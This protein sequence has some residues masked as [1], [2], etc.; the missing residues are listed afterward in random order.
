MTPRSVRPAP[1]QLA[2]A[3]AAPRRVDRAGLS[4]VLGTVAGDDTLLVV[5]ADGTAGS[6]L[7]RE[8]A[9]LAGLAGLTPG[10][11]R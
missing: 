3:P 4:D 11:K 10:G 1:R 8:L 9:G 5:A 2:G 6:D 7:A